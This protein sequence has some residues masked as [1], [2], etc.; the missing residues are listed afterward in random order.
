MPSQRNLRDTKYSAINKSVANDSHVKTAYHIRWDQR[1]RM[2]F[3]RRLGSHRKAVSRKNQE[4]FTHAGRTTL[5]KLMWTISCSFPFHPSEEHNWQ[6]VVSC[7]RLQSPLATLPHVCKPLNIGQ[8]SKTHCQVVSLL[9]IL[10]HPN[11][12]QHSPQYSAALL[13]TS[14]KKP[15]AAT[16]E[17]PDWK[18]YDFQYLAARFKL[19]FPGLTEL[20]ASKRSVGQNPSLLP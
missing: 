20:F 3:S 13:Q 18:H 9:I 17:H 19:G 15:Q 12:T 10:H 2:G 1:N 11:P 5:K 14:V 8:V 16:Q 4:L 6:S 7:K